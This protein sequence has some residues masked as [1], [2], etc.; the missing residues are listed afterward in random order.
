[1]IHNVGRVFFLGA[2]LLGATMAVAQAGPAAGDGVGA[3]PGKAGD[4]ASR[5][6]LGAAARPAGDESLP[7]SVDKA[8]GR[9]SR[10]LKISPL[11][12][13]AGLSE[14]A[15]LL[16]S[17]PR[18][19]P[20]PHALIQTAL[21]QAGIV[22]PVHRLLLTR[23]ATSAPA[24]LLD[25]L[26]AQLKTALSSR[27]GGNG[28]GRWTRYGFATH[29]IDAETSCGVLFILESFVTLQPP[30][31]NP[32][33]GQAVLPLTGRLVPPYKK[34]RVVITAPS[35][36]TQSL[37]ALASP[38]KG[39]GEGFSVELRCERPGKYQIEVLGED[40]AGPTVLA[41]FPLYC[42]PPPPAFATVAEA[43]GSGAGAETTTT[44][45]CNGDAQGLLL[46]LLNNERQAA[47][48][49]PVAI[50]ARLTAAAQAHS[51]DMRSHHF[52]A[53]IS[54]RS[55]G[56]ADR[57]RRAG[58]SSGRITEN[59][60]Q[61][62][63]PQLAHSGLVGSPGHR[64]NLLDTDVDHVGLGCTV[65]EPATPGQPRTLLIT[66]LFGA[67][68]PAPPLPAQSEGDV[69]GH[70]NRL[71]AAGKLAALQSDAKLTDLAKQIAAAPLTAEDYDSRGAALVQ[72]ALPQLAGQ[73]ARLKLGLIGVIAPTDFGPVRSFMEPRLTHLGVAVRPFPAS[74][75]GG[76]AGPGPRGLVI[77]VLGERGEK[78]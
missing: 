58:V 23:F 31:R 32:P 74:S 42:G 26:P 2:V 78:Q 71:R 39:P 52:V 33:V 61:A 14:A 44:F 70:V 46:T 18:C 76:S 47:G 45:T 30:P 34:A 8:L 3:R 54:P 73:F 40:R 25:G 55:G 36:E 12:R 6:G 13:D 62:S 1:M 7:D 56:P 65:A 20:P 38:G 28:P 21:W 69:V 10:E 5:S 60:A 43:Q 66:Q 24:D 59:L 49:K 17:R 29:A 9:T 22:E 53:H 72:T 11:Q 50:D 77:L 57:A 19:D 63:T 15:R 27:G 51:E 37:Q 41:N 68:A 67:L 16:A 48:R 64:A 75:K 4:A 35:G